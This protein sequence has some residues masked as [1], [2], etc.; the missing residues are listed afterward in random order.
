[1]ARPVAADAAATK[2]RILD[3]AAKLFAERGQG[4]TSMRDIA[5]EAK[6][7]LATVHHYFGGKAALYESAVDAMY[8][9]LEGLTGELMPRLATVKSLEEAFVVAIPT[10]LVFVRE[11]LDAV[12]LSMR[13]IL[14]YGEVEAS[15]REKFLLPFLEQ[16]AQVAA[17]LSD[18]DAE[19]AR[20]ALLSLNYLTIRFALS[21]PRELALVTG[22]SD[23]ATDDEALHAEAW[24]RVEQHLLDVALTLFRLPTAS[25]RSE[26]S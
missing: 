19:Q 7:S 9:E 5:G 11:H 25:S 14:D 13:P 21:A 8:E 22:V 4:D 16:G 23:V 20:M 18:V 2:Q 24:A 15:R 12:R 10:A 1:M 3:V 26:M 6:V 17:A